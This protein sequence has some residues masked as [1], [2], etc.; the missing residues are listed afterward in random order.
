MHAAFDEL[1]HALR[2]LWRRRLLA[3]IAVLTLGLGIGLT[4]AMFSIVNGVV[5]RGLPVRDPGRLR[6]ID[7]AFASE[8]SGSSAVPMADFLDWRR[9]QRSFEDLAAFHFT[10]INVSGTP[11]PPER[12]TGALVTANLFDVLG[13]EPAVG[14]RFRPGEDRPGAPPVVIVSDGVWRDHFARARALDALT[15]RADGEVRAVVGV[16]PP[17]FRFP[18]GEDIW[19]PMAVPEPGGARPATPS[20]QVIGRLKPGVSEGAAQADLSAIAARLAQ[21]Y[22]DTNAGVGVVLRTHVRKFMGDDAVG[23]FYAVLFAVIGVLLIAATNVTNL[24]LALGLV[25]SREMAVRAALS[26]SRLRLLSHTLLEALVLAVAGGVLGLAL[27]RV[28]I[29]FFNDAITGTHPP[30]WVD[31]R[32]G[33]R[34]VLFV[35]SLVA[36]V[37][38]VAGAVPAVRASGARAAEILKDE[39]RGSTGGRVGRFSRA[40]VVAEVALS[41]GLLVAAGLMVRTVVAVSGTDFGFSMDDVLTG[42]VTLPAAAYSDDATR[43]RF[44]G[45]LTRRLERQ[46]GIRSV[47]L[48]SVLP[49]TGTGRTPIGLEGVAYASARDYPRVRGLVVGPGFFE[50]FGVRLV[51]G[52]DFG[53]GDGAGAARVAIVNGDFVGRFF[54]GE[55]PLGRRVLVV[56]AEGPP[57][58]VAIVGVAPNLRLGGV[59]NLEPEALYL[60]LGQHAEATMNVAVRAYGDPRAVAPGIRKTVSALDPDLP[61]YG[62]QTMRHALYLTTWFYAVWG[63]VFV[64]F[65]VVALVLVI[66]GLYGLMA[67]SVARRTREIGVRMAMGARRGHVLRLVLS[68]AFVQLA[69]G[70]VAGAVLAAYLSRLLVVLLVGVRPFDPLVLVAVVVAL[71][72]TSVLACLGPALRATRINPTEAL[73]HE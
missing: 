37:A 29:A 20:L 9:A 70:L 42:A 41:F 22:P 18:L 13:V 31:I 58:P 45:E 3:G 26:A 10:V 44:W 21:T 47:A 63:V 53:Q 1:R 8:R 27:A 39:T 68:Q 30:F 23:V 24:L 35:T 14:R 17:G 15:L 59:R 52:R 2:V 6:Y 67:F 60:P 72:A 66:V 43:L 12:Y 7:R 5:L 49:G 32:L 19:I 62:L 40:L 61:V 11:A 25:R 4:A 36:L 48:T 64:V 34:E 57:A 46:A 50:T 54:G 38:A 28:G 16:M 56:P 65:G 55:S 73:R 51:A 69:V 71:V 33:G